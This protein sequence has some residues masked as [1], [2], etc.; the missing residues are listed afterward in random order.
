MPGPVPDREGNLARPR[1]RKGKEYATEVTRGV[2]LPTEPPD[3]DPEWHPIAL[4]LWEGALSSGQASFYQNSDYAML[5]SLCD[6]IS[7]IKKR[8]QRSAQMLATVYSAMTSLLI[9]EGD[10]RRVRV[11][12][13]PPVAP[14]ATE[15]EEALEEYRAQLLQLVPKE[16]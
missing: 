5:Y 2:A 13:D 14:I 3:P 8:G 10:R 7:Y 9:T 16:A 12:L 1:S 4:M 11:E 15:G 6:D